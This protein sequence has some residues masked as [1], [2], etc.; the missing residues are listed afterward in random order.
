[1][2]RDSR[3]LTCHHCSKTM[4][5]VAQ[6]IEHL[7][8]HGVKRYSCGLCSYRAAQCNVVR[9]HMKTCH[10]VSIVDDVPTGTGPVSAEETHFVLYPRDMVKKFLCSKLRTGLI[11]A[12]SRSKNQT[13]SCR[14]ACSIPMKSI[15]PFVVKCAHCGYSSK[16]RTNM[17]RHLSLHEKYFE[18]SNG[19]S[20]EGEEI[21][22]RVIIPDQAPVNPVPHLEGKEKMFDKMTNLAYSSHAPENNSSKGRMGGRMGALDD[23]NHTE[24]TCPPS[25]VPDHQRYVC[26]FEGCGHL[27][28][29]ETMLKYHL[30]T[31]HKNSVLSCPHCPSG[32]L[33]ATQLSMDA[34]K[35][36]LK[37]H[38]PCLHKCGHCFFYHCYLQEIEHHLIEKHPNRPPWQIIIREPDDTGVKRLQNSNKSGQMENSWH[39]SMCK[40]VSACRTEIL[41]HAQSCHGTQSQFKCALCPVRCNVRSEF[42]RHFSSRHPGQEVQV[43][44][45]FYK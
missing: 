34:F 4:K 43:L 36:H 21:I 25:F 30:Q 41:A 38:G 1:M 35:V 44:P 19:T 26:G 2:A 27:T 31:L 13:F 32:R 39:C 12:G 3:L 14:E 11:G 8:L 33:D 42:E 16:V 10:R 6:L 29:N 37:M 28:I 15:L 24:M 22:P 23:Q 18:V 7:A 5:Q 45:M 9:K 20:S 17:I 40:H